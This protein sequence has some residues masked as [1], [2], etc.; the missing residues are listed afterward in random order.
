MG[1]EGMIEVLNRTELHFYPQR[2]IAK[3]VPAVASRQEV[4][5]KEP[6]DNPS[7]ERHIRNFLLSIRGEE[8]PIAPAR[9]GQIAAIPGHIATLSF[10][11]NK[12]VYWTP[13]QKNSATPENLK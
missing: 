9:V 10:K 12:K 5:V 4:H 1:H 11:N 2:S 13:G 3:W 6:M 8:K 7:V